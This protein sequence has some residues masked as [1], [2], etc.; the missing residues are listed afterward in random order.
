MALT[1]GCVWGLRESPLG[2]F[3]EVEDQG[4]ENPKSS[5]A[6]WPKWWLIHGAMCL[7]PELKLWKLLQENT[8]LMQS[9]R[10][11]FFNPVKHGGHNIR[12]L[13]KNSICHCHHC[14]KMH[15]SNDG[16]KCVVHTWAFIKKENLKW[17]RGIAFC[18]SVPLSSS[19]GEEL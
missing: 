6:K 10:S 17:P 4:R 8:T 3:Q 13:I 18:P 15:R 12:H 7:H 11:P 19:P 1:P 9:V 5:A 2:K 16:S 14:Y